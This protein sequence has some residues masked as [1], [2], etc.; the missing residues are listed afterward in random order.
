MKRIFLVY[1]VDRSDAFDQVARSH[2]AWEADVG[3]WFVNSGDSLSRL[4]HA[5]KRALKPTQT[6]LVAP[7]PERPKFK[8]LSAG[9]LAWII[10]RIPK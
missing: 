4:Y 8:N 9:S 6:F 3:L 1:T 7:L 5:L 2:E 10:A